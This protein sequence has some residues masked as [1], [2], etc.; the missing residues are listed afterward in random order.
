MGRTIEVN[1]VTRIEGHAKIALHLDDAGNVASA[2]L[3]VL[4]IR[5]FEKLLDRTE[6]FKMPL[7]T[8]RICGVCPVAHHMVSVLAIENGL[9]VQAPPEARLLREL[10]Y[11]GNIL[12]SHSLS[13]FVLSGPD[14]VLGIGAP[15]A[16]RNVFN[17]LRLA[18]ELVM[19]MLRLRTIG[20]RIVETVGGRGIHPVT[21]V[22]GGMASRP[23][24]EELATIAQ[25]ASQASA[26]L[27]EI[28][29]VLAGKLPQLAE[30][31]DWVGLPPQPLALSRAGEHSY[32]DGNCTVLDG[33]GSITRSFAPAEYGRHL[34]EHVLPGSYMKAVRIRAEEETSYFV[35][36]LARLNVND[37]IAG[38]QAQQM[39]EELH[40]RGRPSLAALDNIEARLIEMVSAAERA[41][42][43]AGEELC[44]GPIRVDCE[45]RAG[46]FVAA[47]EAPRGLLVHDYTVDKSGRITAANFIVATQ[48]NYDAINEAV[49]QAAQFCLPRNDEAFLMNGMEFALRCFDPCLSCATHSAGRLPMEV[50][51]Y[52]HGKLDRT[53]VRRLDA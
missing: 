39:L 26:L 36:P 23:A 18:P 1:P 2:Q 27:E 6:L 20:Q 51:I 11:L 30:F 48:N 14:V 42:A 7:I 21:A 35:G 41:G 29:G 38:R 37:R 32:L 46:R 3:K 53:I 31:R 34:V 44:G 9:G 43:I 12:H 49:R 22:P 24:K 16:D 5:G 52:R 40:A 15:P 50:R 33:S 28:I 25:W 47:V 13:V 19:K 10:M 8:A 4:E 17:L 45:P